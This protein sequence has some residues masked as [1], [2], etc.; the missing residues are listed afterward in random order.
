MCTSTTLCISSTALLNAPIS[1]VQ[2]SSEPESTMEKEVSLTCADSHVCQD[3][4]A[5]SA[6]PSP[7]YTPRSFMSSWKSRACAPS[8]SKP[9]SST[10]AFAAHS[11]EKESARRRASKCRAQCLVQ[12]IL[13]CMQRGEAV[14]CTRGFS[15]GLDELDH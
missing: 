6:V 9:F 14:A 4:Q 7:A 1:S 10:P 12:I 15:T 8:K 11:C 3:H 5:E 2:S 13:N